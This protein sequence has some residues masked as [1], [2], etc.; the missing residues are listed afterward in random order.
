M[1]QGRQGR[2]LYQSIVALSLATGA[3]KNV[4]QISLKLLRSALRLIKVPSNQINSFY[5]C[6]KS[7]LYH[8]IYS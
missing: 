5:S 7:K 6:V 1:K 3:E 4:P 2:E 8:G